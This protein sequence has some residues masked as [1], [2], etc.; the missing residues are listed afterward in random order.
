MAQHDFSINNQS[1]PAFRG[2]LNNALEALATLSSGASAPSTTYANMLWYD[3]ANNILYMRSEADDAWISLGTLDQGA[4]TFTPA[5]VAKLTQ[6]QV[7]NA[8]STVFGQVS[9]QR[10]AQAGV[11]SFA[12]Q[13]QQIGVGQTWQ[14]VTRVSGTSYQNTTGKPI[15]FS[16]RGGTGANSLQVSVDNVTWVT[17]V[18][19]DASSGTRDF[20]TAI[21]PPD[22]Y[23]RGNDIFGTVVELR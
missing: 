4:N 10:V 9:G 3:T 20:L 6:T 21:I 23:Y 12:D 16:F 13:E 15:Q 1:A 7:E 18:T 8:A 14:A 22:Y 17:V 19:N 11:V 2:D 5:G